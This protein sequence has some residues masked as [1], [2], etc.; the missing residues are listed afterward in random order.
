MIS[1]ERLLHLMSEKG[2]SDLYLSAGA[3]VSVKINGVCV[4]LNQERLSAPSVVA[5]LGGLLSDAQMHELEKTRELN[6]G[7][8]I[9]GAGNFRLSA[10]QQRGAVSA[11]IR[12]I[13]KEVPPLDS[14]LLP[15]ILKALI[16]ERRGLILVVGAAGSGKSTTIASMLDHRNETLTGHVLTIED[17][18]EYLFISKKSIFNQ[19]EIGTDVESLQVA[20]RNAMRQAPDVIFIG[21]IRDREA[22]SAALAYALSGHLVVATMHSTNAAQVLN[23]VISFYTPET[24]QALFQELAV[25]LRAVV[26]QRLVRSRKGGRVPAVE[27]LINQGQI[28]GLVERGDVQSIKDAMEQ[29]LAPESQTF[30]QSLYALLQTDIITREDALAAADSQNNLLWLINNSGKPVAPQGKGADK[31]AA[32]PSASFSEFTLNI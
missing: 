2:A 18:V 15:N 20:L 23:R 30:E 27:I 22:M 14:L 8:R 29:S 25:S 32:P 9:E 3:P 16:K 5:L 19:R 10:F 31:E 17:P 7:V 12:F 28:T 21:E 24:R 1:L 4:P 11:V 13:P 6:L 26:S